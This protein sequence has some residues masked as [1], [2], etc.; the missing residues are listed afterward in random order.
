MNTRR[1]TAITAKY[2]AFHSQAFALKQLHLAV[3]APQV[4]QLTNLF[5]VQCERCA[6]CLLTKR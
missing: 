5:K 6:C 2:A 3:C 1:G 4:I